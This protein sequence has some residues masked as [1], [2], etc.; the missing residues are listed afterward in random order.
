MAVLLTLPA[1]AQAQTFTNSYG[2][3]G[4]TDNGNGTASITG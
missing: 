1:V 3:W 4:Y 2:I